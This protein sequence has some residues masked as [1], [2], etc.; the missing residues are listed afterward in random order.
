MGNKERFEELL[1]RA[2]DRPG[3]DGLLNYI[4]KSDFYTA[5]AS[6]K[7]HLSCEGGLLQHSLNVYD[8]LFGRLQPGENDTFRYLVHGKEVVAFKRETLVIVALL[9]DLCKTNFYE[10]E[11]RNQKTYDP[12]KSKSGIQLAGEEGQCR[13]V[14]LGVR[15]MLHH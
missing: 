1:K 11:M 9:H 2:A 13:S 7:F 4:R 10:T 5:P 12:E 8:A 14:H 15:A 3:F 6:T